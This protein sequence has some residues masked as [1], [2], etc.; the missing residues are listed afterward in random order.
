MTINNQKTKTRIPKV[1]T[2]IYLSIEEDAKQDMM[3]VRTLMQ[4][5]E[6]ELMVS[7][8]GM[9]RESRPSSEPVKIEVAID[10]IHVSP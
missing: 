8:S 9:C 7:D 6:E 1:T 5:F 4:S 3:T 10:G 2:P